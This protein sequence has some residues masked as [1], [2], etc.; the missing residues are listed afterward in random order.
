[1]FINASVVGE[2]TTNAVRIKQTKNIEPAVIGEIVPKDKGITL[3]EC[4]VEKELTHPEVDPFR[5]A[6]AREVGG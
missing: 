5:G 2:I 6:F 3:V 4:G 1:M